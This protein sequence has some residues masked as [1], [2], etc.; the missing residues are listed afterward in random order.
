MATRRKPL[1]R[2]RGSGR[3]EFKPTSAQREQVEILVAARLSE[4]AIA[5]AIGIAKMTLRKHF[6]A[7]LYNGPARNAEILVAMF[8]TALAGNV[9]AQRAWLQRVEMTPPR[10]A[11][12]KPEPKPKSL[13][14]KEEQALAAAAPPADPSWAELVPGFADRIVQ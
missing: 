3:P 8:K 11:R 4:Q 10:A 12:E 7:E 14:K 6:A 13:G 9:T 2:R 1:K 5:D